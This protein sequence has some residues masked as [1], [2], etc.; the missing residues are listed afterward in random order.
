[1]PLNQPPCD[2]KNIRVLDWLGHRLAM[3]GLKLNVK[4]TEY[5]A[6]DVHELG[7]IMMNGTGLARDSAFKCLGSAI[8]SEDGLK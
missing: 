3:F 1:M 8:A 4:K 5:L 6:T 2:S 7:L